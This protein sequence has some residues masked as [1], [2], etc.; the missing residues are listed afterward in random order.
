[1]KEKKNLSNFFV[2]SRVE[3]CLYKNTKP[4]NLLNFILITFK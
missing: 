3:I 1:M 4:P 2:Q